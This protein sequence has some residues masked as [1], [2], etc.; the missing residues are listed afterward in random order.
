MSSAVMRRFFRRLLIGFASVLVLLVLAVAVIYLWP[1]DDDTLRPAAQRLSF[2]EARARIDATAARE[3]QDPAIRPE[4]RSQALLHEENDGASAKSVLLLHGYHDCPA[5]FRELAARFHAQGYNVYVPLAPRH[6]T[7]DPGADADLQARELADYAAQAMDITAALGS[8]AGV[9]GLSG[10]GVLATQLATLR[11]GQVRHLLVISPFY[12]PATAQAPGFLVKPLTVLFG[13]RLVPDLV[14]SNGFSFA[15]LSQYLRLAAI[16]RTGE[17]V[18]GLAS[19]AVVTSPNDPFIDL[20]RAREVPRE[21]AAVN[22]L[23]LDSY[24]IP[25]ETG[26]GHDAVAPDGLNGHGA[27]LYQRY[28]QMYEGLR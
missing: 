18:S 27:D 19:V 21:I 11:P 5:Q 25:A 14:N 3:L 6:G 1:L 26:V 2:A 9:I 22:D 8:E 24:E 4:C 15:A 7:V 20:S 12:R 10:G 13:H 16:T 17:R 23:R 28:Q